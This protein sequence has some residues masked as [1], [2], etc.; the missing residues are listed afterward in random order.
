MPFGTVNILAVI[1]SAIA[2]FALGFVW[3]TVIFR[4]PYLEGLGKTADAL[5]RGPSV[6]VASGMQL[7]GNFVMAYILA[8]LMQRTGQNTVAGGVWLGLVVWLGFVAAVIGPMYAYQAFPLKFF[9]IS[10]G[11][12]LV[13]LLLMGTILGAWKV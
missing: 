7:V 13:A 9:A 11:Y 12:P 8:W 2:N 3:F 4:N 1:A 5:A 10:A 6:L